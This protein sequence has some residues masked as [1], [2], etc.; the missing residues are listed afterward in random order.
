MLYAGGKKGASLAD[1]AV[2]GS[3]KSLSYGGFQHESWHAEC[4]QKYVIPGELCAAIL[5]VKESH[6]AKICSTS[7]PVDD[8]ADNKAINKEQMERI[9]KFCF[10]LLDQILSEQQFYWNDV[11]VCFFP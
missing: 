6:V 1:A 10:Y 9:A 8:D 4:L 2:V 3:S 7:E 11:T 5:S